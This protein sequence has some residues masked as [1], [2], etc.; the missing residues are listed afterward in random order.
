MKV[1][2]VDGHLLIAIDEFRLV[3]VLDGVSRW[4]WE[5]LDEKRSLGDVVAGLM[6]R[7]VVSESVARR[8]VAHLTREFR[9]RG[10]IGRTGVR[11][12]TRPPGSDIAQPEAQAG[13]RPPGL[14][15]CRYYKLA[16]MHVRI[17][18]DS[19]SVLDAME[20]MIGHLKV[21]EIPGA[22]RHMINVWCDVG[23]WHVS[24]DN[25]PGSLCGPL[26]HAITRV[27]R[28]L[29]SRAAGSAP[30]LLVLHAGAVCSG[31][32]GLIL[33]GSSK[34]GKSTLTTALALH[35]FDYL[36]DDVIPI[37]LDSGN[38]VPLPIAPCLRPGSWPVIHKMH[39]SLEGIPDFDRAGHTVKYLPLGNRLKL[40]SS[41]T[42][43][44]SIMIF[45]QWKEGAENQLTRL[46]RAEAI[47]TLAESSSAFKLDAGVSAI[48][49]LL[50]W[51]GRIQLYSFVYSDTDRAVRQLSEILCSDR[52]P[53]RRSCRQSV[54]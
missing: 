31:S 42:I 33:A 44:P 1:Y 13:S 48:E 20:P 11:E 16:D 43:S 35:G 40:T 21:D 2:P 5:R 39:E 23:G 47:L 37:D 22:L 10:L 45:P 54:D 3:Y 52:M 12:T 15:F 30:R 29:L 7:Y 4:I 53:P 28:T 27:I 32:R 25:D 6:E 51:L 9:K 8:D 36:G 34:R 18:T 41:D 49:S 24:L 17:S 38:I 46:S 14:S 19:R 50:E 26:H